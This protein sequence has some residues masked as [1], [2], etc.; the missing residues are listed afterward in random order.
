[1]L[2][3][4]RNILAQVAYTPVQTVKTVQ[5]QSVGYNPFE[6][7]TLR[8]SYNQ[9]YAVNKPVKGGFFAGYYNGKQNIVGRKLFVDA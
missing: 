2:N 8:V 1:M 3:H 4:L 7:G 5:N 6:T 9:N